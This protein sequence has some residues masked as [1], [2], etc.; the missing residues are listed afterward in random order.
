V[1]VASTSVQG[2][3][4][5]ETVT[6]DTGAAIRGWLGQRGF[7]VPAAIA[8]VLDAYASEG[9]EFIV[10]RLRP[11][12]SVQAMQPVRL[13]TPSADPTLPLR[14]MAAGIGA[15]VDITL[16]VVSE[17]R[18]RAQGFPEGA[19]DESK[20]VW[21]GARARS[22]YDDVARAA[23]SAGDGRAW[24]TEVA[25]PLDMEL[26]LTR[27]GLEETYRSTCVPSAPTC[28]EAG[29]DAGALADADADTDADAN[30]DAS[31]D[32]SVCAPPAA[33]DDF[34]LATRDLH[35]GSIWLTRL[36]ASLPASALGAG[37]LRLEAAPSQTQVTGVRSAS[38][39]SDPGYDPCSAPAAPSADSGVQA[40]LQRRAG[41]GVTVLVGIAGAFVLL[42][43]RRRETSR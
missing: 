2:P 31:A 15:N 27:P 29:A 38:T 18:Y 25:G 24:L 43:R 28:A 5:I 13:V 42:K 30:G 36:R 32:A 17:G 1:H 3:Y 35:A 34:A 40:R 11:G 4:A 19:L 10:V 16:Y 7:V 22:N 6:G 8:P 33:C 26:G 23:M 21:D 12:A 41:D 20:L 39:F 9:F 14:M 37:D